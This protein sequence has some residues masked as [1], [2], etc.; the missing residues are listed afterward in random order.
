LREEDRVGVAVPTCFAA[1]LPPWGSTAAVDRELAVG[2][3]RKKSPEGG[4]KESSVTGTQREGGV[5]S[6][7]KPPPPHSAA[8]AAPTGVFAHLHLA[9]LAHQ[10]VCSQPKPGEIRPPLLV[11]DTGAI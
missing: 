1:V 2:R 10:P 6:C 11:W 9:S 7:R 3:R 5:A 8:V 4:G